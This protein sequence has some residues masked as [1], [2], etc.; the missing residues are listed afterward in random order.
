MVEI[1]GVLGR[2]TGEEDGAEGRLL[3]LFDEYERRETREA[4]VVK[5]LDLL[6]MVLQAWEYEEKY[7]GI[8]LGEFFR[9]TPPSRFRDGGIRAVAEEVHRRRGGCTGGA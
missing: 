1:A 4:V 6:D 2:A 7:P 5:D 3:G 8:D 9:G